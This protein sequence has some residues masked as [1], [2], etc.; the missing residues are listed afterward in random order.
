MGVTFLLNS[1]RALLYR[2]LAY[3]GDLRELEVRLRPVLREVELIGDV[4]TATNV[5]TGPQVWLRLAADRPDLA[6]ADLAWV[7]E[8]L[9]RSRFLL[10]HYFYL[11]A[12]VMA[13][14]YEGRAAEGLRR[15]DATGPALRRSLLLRLAVIRG[16]ATELRARVALAVAAAEPAQRPR[17]LR[18]V[19][20]AAQRLDA[21]GMGF[22]TAHAALLRASVALLR[23]RRAEALREGASAEELFAR[24]DM[25]LFAAAVAYGRSLHDADGEAARRRAEEVFA[26]EGVEAPA[27]F[28]RMLAP[29]W[30]EPSES[31]K[32][33]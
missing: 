3:R 16:L 29:V 14:L 28:A 33:G 27:R 20:R 18:D 6:S 26:A 22:T 8:R 25:R 2:A 23:G 12:H 7:E 11:Q 13:A 4:H 30:A 32:P 21:E 17:L 24:A 31:V 9:P 10:Q 5:R 19:D 15:Y 1:V